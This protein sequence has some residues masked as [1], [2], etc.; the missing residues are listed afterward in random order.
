MLD[1]AWRVLFELRQTGQLTPRFTKND[2]AALDRR[3][4]KGGVFA[5]VFAVRLASGDL[6]QEDGGPF[7]F[8]D[9]SPFRSSAFCAGT[10]ELFEL[11]PQG[12]M[13][14]GRLERYDEQFQ[15]GDTSTPRS[16]A[17]A[18]RKKS[19]P[20]TRV[21]AIPAEKAPEPELVHSRPLEEVRREEGDLRRSLE[22]AEARLRTI[23]AE[24]QV[25]MEAWALSLI[26]GF[27]AAAEPVQLR[28][29]AHLEAQAQLETLGLRRM[30]S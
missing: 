17:A 20:P 25:L 15:S 29:F 5:E 3:F 1:E 28:V 18:A 14:R 26:G 21:E 16:R 22:D 19:V 13:L 2:A 6:L 10:W 30:A 9:E 4:A 23:Q 8:T 12:A 7:R 24:R 27:L 11:L